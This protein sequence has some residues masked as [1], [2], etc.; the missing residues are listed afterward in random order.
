MIRG[1]R[2]ITVWRAFPAALTRALAGA[3]LAPWCPACGEPAGRHV[4]G[5]CMPCWDE[6]DAASCGAGGCGPGPWVM[7]GKDEEPGLAV[8]AVGSYE[9]RLRRI[10][11]CFKFRETPG[12]GAPLGERLATRAAGSRGE[13]DVIVPVPLHWRR[14][15]RRG[16]NQAELLGR[17][18]A[19]ALRCPQDRLALRRLRPTAAQ[20]GR[21]RDERALN[22]RQAFRARASRVRGA[23]VLLV[24]DVVTT[25]ATLRE[26]AR[27]LHAAGAIDVRAAVVAR[28]MTRSDS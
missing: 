11:R 20:S 27:V 28:T 9:G 2:D 6:V 1:L 18:V 24:D 16:Y 10:V 8:W 5:V 22:V 25:G 15:R 7:A 21:S 12:L 19:R 4:A 26:C 17:Q 3:V 14:R 23:R 13:V